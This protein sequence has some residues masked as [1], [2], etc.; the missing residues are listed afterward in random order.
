MAK[1]EISP[2]GSEKIRQGNLR[3]WLEAAVERHGDTF[4]YS[5]TDETYRAQKKPVWIFC[6]K[7]KEWFETTPANHIRFDGGGCADC[8]GEAK[9]A[10]RASAGEPRFREWLEREHGDRLELVGPFG[11]M[12]KPAQ[13]RCKVH[14]TVKTTKPTAL[15]VNG[16]LGCDACSS[17]SRSSKQRLTLA[18]I[19]T[20][21][22]S[23]LPDHIKLKSAEWTDN[24]TRILID[25]E[26]HGQ[27]K[28]SAS[29]LRRSPHK[30][31]KCGRLANGYAGER[32]RR[33]I[34]AG[35][36]GR[37]C[38]LG[39]MEVRVF[40]IATLKVGVS[41]RDLETRYSHHLSRIYYSA[42]MPEKYAYVIENRLH[43]KFYDHHDTRILKAGMRSGERWSG[44]TELYWMRQ[45]QEIIDFIERQR[46]EIEEGLYDDQEELRAFIKPEFFERDVNRPKNLTRRPVAVVGVDPNT[47]EV[48]ER[49]DSI[50]AATRSG[51]RNLSLVLALSSARQLS[52]GLRWFKADEFDPSSIPEMNQRHGV[53]PVICVET[54]EVFRSAMDAETVMQ[55]RGYAVSRDKVTM[56]CKG[57]RKAAGGY[58][59]RRV[60]WSEFV[61]RGARL[62]NPDVLPTAHAKN[63][64]KRVEKY[65]PETN[66]VVAV[67]ASISEAARSIGSEAGSLSTA[68]KK[69][70]AL[71]GHW[72]RKR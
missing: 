23:D 71:K 27:S 54:N 51:Y 9:G 68:L 13:F 39:V 12:T 65:L 11:G 38:H 29:Y 34:D 22:E 40:D 45:K 17:E 43:R 19:R 26:F 64:S 63:V 62:T 48:R 24:G 7:H 32:L 6:I 57:S 50:S 2:E 52:G 31:P 4:D 59:W 49:F 25:C 35:E 69:G 47:N 20:D 60:A 36:L 67:Y 21:V 46:R 66:E 5:R 30:C 72:F 8:G 10:S 15:S 16:Y 55:E 42:T 28:V 37:P 14:G 44:D 33:L 56:V 58:H 1:R 61:H 53:D 41:T 3:R 18:K 70:R